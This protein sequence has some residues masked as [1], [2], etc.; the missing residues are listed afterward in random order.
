V[1]RA[2]NASGQGRS[3][4]ASNVDE[5]HV[6]FERTE[7]FP[8]HENSGNLLDG[9][10]RCRDPVHAAFRKVSLDLDMFMVGT[11][12]EVSALI[13]EGNKTDMAQPD[14]VDPELVD[15]S[16]DV[17]EE[18]ESAMPDAAVPE[19]SEESAAIEA[20]PVPTRAKGRQV[21][22]SVRTLLVATLIAALLASAGVLAWLYMG[23]NTKFDEQTR[24]TADNNRAERIALDYAVASAEI[25]FK[26][27]NTWK[28]SLVNNTTPELKAKLDSAGASM[29]QLLTP[30]QWNSTATPLVAK[31]R[32][33][34]NGIYVVDAFVGVQTKTSQAPEGV[35]STATY[36]VTIDSVHDWKISDVG[37]IGSVVGQ[38]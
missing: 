28:K 12:D 16:V 23:A 20:R 26:D 8:H 15:E 25:D 5:H 37:G 38:K 36:S 32:S 33:N 35:Q 9:A 7:E 29:E 3:V 11:R 17:Q 18:F 30:L 2:E 22:V 24:Q 14:G 1:Q 6:V 27:L 34:D 21:S 19:D 31:V 4:L 10:R 13:D